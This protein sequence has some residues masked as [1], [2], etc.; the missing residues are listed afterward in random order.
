MTEEELNDLAYIHR[1]TLVYFKHPKHL[2]ALMHTS[3]R[4]VR[5][6]VAEHG[7]DKHRDILAHDPDWLVRKEVAKHGNE[8]HARALLKDLHQHVQ[9]YAYLRLKKLGY[10]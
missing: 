2:N 6:E 1:I 7:T 9:Y 3:N 4:F 5:K 10:K 8:H